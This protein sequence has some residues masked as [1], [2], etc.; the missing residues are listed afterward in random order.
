MISYP[1]EYNAKI[2]LFGEYTLLLGS[3]ALTIPFRK[4]SARLKFNTDPKPKNITSGKNLKKFYDYLDSRR[5]DFPVGLDVD[6]DKFK[7]D[8]EDGLFL[9]SDI[10]QGYG[11][12]SSGVLVASVYKAYSKNPLI[13]EQGSNLIDLKKYFSFMESF[14][15][16]T[17]SGLDPLSCYAQKPIRVSSPDK[18]EIVEFPSEK[19]DS[20]FYIFLVDT[21]LMSKTEGLVQL[22]L[23]KSNSPKYRKV[24]LN[25]MIPGN[26]RCIDHVLEGRIRDFLSEV[27]TLSGLQLEIFSEM[28]PDN[29]KKLWENGITTGNYS[30]KLC[31]SGGGGFILGFTRDM[32]NVSSMF[33]E[34][35]Q[36]VL[37]VFIN[38]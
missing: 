29:Y 17:S 7:T 10:P 9:D 15:H 37:P 24:L 18:I 32:E 28:I 20:V 38:G 5:P 19:N 34:Y 11:I 25:S 35:G 27:E 2:L 30:F 22:F 8:L 33:R 6:P 26:N 12:G 16:G 36:K 3:R 31:G 14:F 13:P 4:F 21:G 1:P 23:E